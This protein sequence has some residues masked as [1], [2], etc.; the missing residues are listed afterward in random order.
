M[1]LLLLTCGCLYLT[2]GQM[3]V[4]SLWDQPQLLHGILTAGGDLSCSLDCVLGCA[5]CYILIFLGVRVL[6]SCEDDVRRWS[7]SWRGSSVNWFRRLCTTESKATALAT[8]WLNV[9]LWVNM[10][11]RTLESVNNACLCAGWANVNKADR[12]SFTLPS[13]WYNFSCRFL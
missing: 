13:I 7:L 8:L 6:S 9:R 11:L 10:S 3:S 12:C 5:S 4:A 1:F 2:N